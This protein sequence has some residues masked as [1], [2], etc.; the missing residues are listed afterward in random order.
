MHYIF[1]N[2]HFGRASSL[3]AS[4]IA[5][6]SGLIIASIPLLPS[7]SHWHF[8]SQTGIC[9]PLPFVGEEMYPGHSYSFSVLIV[10]N[11]FLFVLIACGQMVIYWSVQANIL[12]SSVTSG[13]QAK[14][15]TI[16]T[17]FSSKIA[18]LKSLR[19]W[20]VGYNLLVLIQTGQIKLLLHLS[21]YG[22]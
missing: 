22:G 13:S 16:A 4:G 1:Q 7:F 17:R 12:D 20:T 21:V 8:F 6:I 10:L 11:F 14:D 15:T 9:V 2:L 3:V 19:I 5:W 18:Q